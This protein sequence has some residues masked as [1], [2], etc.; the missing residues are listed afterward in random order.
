MS[1]VPRSI[2]VQQTDS[3]THSGS[4]LTPIIASPGMAS[5]TAHPPDGPMVQ[6]V[7]STFIVGGQSSFNGVATWPPTYPQKAVM[8]LY[9]ASTSSDA[10]PAVA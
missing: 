6:S 9:A 1:L 4:L 8:A 5:S 7:G 10:V 2:A 3:I